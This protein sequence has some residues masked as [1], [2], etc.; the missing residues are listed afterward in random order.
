MRSFLLLCFALALTACPPTRSSG[1][2]DDDSAS[3]GDDDDA[4]MGDCPA[5]VCE[6]DLVSASA[7]CDGPTPEPMPDGMML[8]SSPA[9]GQL[10]AY[11]FDV[12]GG[13]CPE[14][15]VAGYAHLQ[16]GFIEVEFELLNDF[17]DCICMLDVEYTFEGIPAGSWEVRVLTT[18]ATGSVEIQ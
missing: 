16:E 14:L 12:S 11:H 7:P 8:L 10:S 13:C 3:A 15:G 6:L 17:C 1:T 9:P 4:T 5:G 18:G 2:D